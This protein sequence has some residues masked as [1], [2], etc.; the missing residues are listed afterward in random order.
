MSSYE[1]DFYAWTNEQTQLLRSGKLGEIDV[2]NIAEELES[3]GKSEKRELENRL[4]VLLAHLL[5]WQ[6]QPEHRGKSWLATIDE[7]RRR[8]KKHL[9]ES[10]SLKPTIPDAVEDAHQYALAELLR[11][12]PFEKNDLPAEC[13]YSIE[14]IINPGFY[15]DE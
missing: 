3:L 1:T 6:L 12:T 14:Q 13:P 2:A 8:L 5:K 15:P 9:K 11:V 4:V 7:Q 10:P